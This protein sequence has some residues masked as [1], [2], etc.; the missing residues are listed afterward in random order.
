[1]RSIKENIG[2]TIKSW[3]NCDSMFEDF[4]H[5]HIT[6]KQFCG[7]C[8]RDGFKKDHYHCGY[9]LKLSQVG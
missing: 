5:F 9:C 8:K 4:Y 2:K 6:P 3:C 7:I 1:M